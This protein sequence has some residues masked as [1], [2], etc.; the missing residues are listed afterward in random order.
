MEKKY[1]I[2]SINE[3]QDLELAIACYMD[4]IEEKSAPIFGIFGTYQAQDIQDKLEN[5]ERLLLKIETI[6]F[7]YAKNE[8]APRG[9]N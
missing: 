4:K 2:F 9:K 3:L 8:K 5:L 1:V 6:L 7:N